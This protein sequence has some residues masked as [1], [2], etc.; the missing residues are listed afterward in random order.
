LFTGGQITSVSSGIYVVGVFTAIRNDLLVSEC[1]VGI[2]VGI[3][4]TTHERYQ[5]A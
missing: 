1:F 5:H 2:F 3:I 4:G